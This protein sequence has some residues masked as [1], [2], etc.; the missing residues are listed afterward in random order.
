MDTKTIAKWSYVAG[1][2]LSI[3]AAFAGY[4]PQWLTSLLILLGALAGLFGDSDNAKKTVIMYLGLYFTF[5]SLAGFIA[6]GGFL[7]TLLG[8]YVG[9]LGPVVLFTVLVNG[10]KAY[11]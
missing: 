5:E 9:F 4:G 3:I 8:A 11:L 7:T 6:V 10:Y 1:A 2:L